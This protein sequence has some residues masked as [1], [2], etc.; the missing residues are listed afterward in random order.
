MDTVRYKLKLNDLSRWERGHAISGREEISHDDSRL[1][2][3]L[4]MMRFM[5]RFY[6]VPPGSQPWD[7]G[8]FEEKA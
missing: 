4:S 2:R 3:K 7:S 5:M 6:A 1:P 8:G